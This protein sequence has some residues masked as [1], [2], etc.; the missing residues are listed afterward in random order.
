MHWK[1]CIR[2]H[3]VERARG[4]EQALGLREA[5]ALLL[6]EERVGFPRVLHLPGSPVELDRLVEVAV[7]LIE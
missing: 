3:R 4:V 1:S 7:Q 5:L 6:G 2:I